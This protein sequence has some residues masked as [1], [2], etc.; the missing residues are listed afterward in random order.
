MDLWF[1]TIL[2][3][4]ELCSSSTRISHSKRVQNEK[5]TNITFIRSD[6]GE[7]LKMKTFKRCQEQLNK[8]EL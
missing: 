6:H 8:I 5:C 3:E 2:Y 4:H 1:M 7:N